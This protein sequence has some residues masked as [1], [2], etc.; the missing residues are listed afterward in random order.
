MPCVICKVKSCTLQKA[1][2][3]CSGCPA[4]M[5]LFNYCAANEAVLVALLS[6]RYSTV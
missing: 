6:L 4:E 3:T 1:V 2:M 5:K